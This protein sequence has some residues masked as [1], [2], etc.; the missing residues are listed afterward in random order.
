[1]EIYPWTNQAKKMRCSMPSKFKVREVLKTLEKAG[2][3]SRMPICDNGNMI[4]QEGHIALKDDM[5]SIT[6]KHLAPYGFEE[7]EL[8]L[9]EHKVTDPTTTSPP[10]SR[11]QRG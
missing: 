10:I 7:V 2:L 1:M 9:A 4:M 11:H 5:T 3:E 8:P 6:R